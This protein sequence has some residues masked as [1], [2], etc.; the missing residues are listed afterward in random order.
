MDGEQDRADHSQGREWLEGVQGEAA[1]DPV[2][3]VFLVPIPRQNNADS[4]EGV[5]NQVHRIV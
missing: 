1:V 4:M 3:C 2:A 5:E